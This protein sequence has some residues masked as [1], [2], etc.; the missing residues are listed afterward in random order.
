MRLK[1]RI[2]LMG[3]DN[4]KVWRELWIPMN[5]TF[6]RFHKILQAAMGWEDFHMYSFQEC[7]ESRYFHIMCPPFDELPGIDATSL[8]INAIMWG[9][10]DSFQMENAIDKLNK[11]DKLYY[12][13]DFGDQWEHEIAVIEF[14]TTSIKFAE[15]TNGGGACPPED[16]GGASGYQRT[17]KY[18][19]GKIKK[20][21][22]YDWFT[23]VDAE[24]IDV[25]MFD[26]DVHNKMLKII[27]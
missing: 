14:D 7:L 8:S 10:F 11:V 6:D 5:I 17:K 24:D 27:K 13:Y 25:H 16:C 26:M 19:D 12:I 4:P 9:Y 22:Y 20:E 21:E 15:I 23:A 18:L 2:E 1:V 3:V